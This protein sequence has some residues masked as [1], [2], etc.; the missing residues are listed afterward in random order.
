MLLEWSQLTHKQS[1]SREKA[2]VTA[3]LLFMEIWYRSVGKWMQSNRKILC[4]QYKILCD[5]CV[6]ASCLFSLK[7]LSWLCLVPQCSAGK[8]IWIFMYWMR[9]NDPYKWHN[10]NTIAKIINN[11]VNY[12]VFDHLKDLCDFSTT[13]LWNFSVRLRLVARIICRRKLGI[14]KYARV[15]YS[16]MGK[17]YIWTIVSSKCLFI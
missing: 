1:T 16:Q 15:G 17:W 9:G 11:A 12:F 2:V 8:K 10:F 7:I 4:Q 13:V 6:N 5:F 14:L 3:Y